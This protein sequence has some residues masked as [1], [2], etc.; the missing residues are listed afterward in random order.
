MNQ[1]RN[2]QEREES[3]M[4]PTT[5]TLDDFMRD[6]LPDGGFVVSGGR[7]L[8]M[9]V[10]DS[11]DRNIWMSAAA[12]EA[13]V[14]EALALSGPI[15]KSGI[16]RAAMDRAAFRHSPGQPDA[17][18]REQMIDGILFINVARPLEIKPPS[19]TGGPARVTVDKAHTLGFEAGRSVSILSLPEGDFV[20]VVGDAV[21]DASRV[22][23]EGGRLRRVDLTKPWIVALPTPT[24][25]FFWFDQP[26]RSFQG[27]ITL[28]TS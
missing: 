5:K 19:Q 1:I 6:S 26:M 28:P 17:A 15:V 12:T 16:G 10:A 18:V 3:P 14:F 22:L 4:D 25:T 13:S 23:P 21:Q 20:E 27:P 11:N 7:D 8:F 24:E 9:E 2:G